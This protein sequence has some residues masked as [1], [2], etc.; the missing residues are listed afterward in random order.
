VRLKDN[1]YARNALYFNLCFVC[2]SWARTVHYEPVVK[3]LTDF[4]VGME[5]ERSFLSMQANDNTR[6]TN[7]LHQVMRDLNASRMCN[8]TGECAVMVMF[9]KAIIT[10]V[11]INILNILSSNRVEMSYKLTEAAV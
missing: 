10:L 9:P 7:M 8:L 2:D 11:G 1:K 4:L 5:V 3:K 6:L